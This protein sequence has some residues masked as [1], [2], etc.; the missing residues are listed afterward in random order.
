MMGN[1]LLILGT[2]MYHTYNSIIH[3]HESDPVY[4]YVFLD[5]AIEFGDTTSYVMQ[6]KSDKS[7][8]SEHP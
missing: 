4:M 6:F 1:T 7:M 3:V 8:S 5:V 2:E